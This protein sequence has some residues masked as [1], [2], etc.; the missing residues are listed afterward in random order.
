MTGDLTRAHQVALVAHEDDG[1]LRLN[2]PQQETQ[3]SGA[4]EAA[5]VGHRK[6]QHANLTL[7]S[8]QVLQRG[9]RWDG[10]PLELRHAKWMHP[11]AGF[12]RVVSQRSFVLV[13]LK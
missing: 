9:R 10:E 12:F 13:G 5:P 7:Q 2:L 6:H 4:V 8:G 11:K 3:L 1:S